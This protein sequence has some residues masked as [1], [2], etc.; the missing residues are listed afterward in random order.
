WYRRNTLNM[1]GPSHALPALLGTGVPIQ[2]N[3]DLQTKGF[4][5]TL[6]YRDKFSKD[7]NFNASVL[8]SDNKSVV[9]RYFNPNKILT[10]YYEGMTIG[11]I[12]GYET[13]GIIQ[14]EDQLAAIPDQSLFFG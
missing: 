8:L 10:T 1:L 9:K 11:E 4:E 5:L 13:V 7:L 12:W 2:N 3:S 14:N 6:S